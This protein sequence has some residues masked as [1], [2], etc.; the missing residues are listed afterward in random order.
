MNIGKSMRIALAMRDM[1]RQELAQLM[2]V[3]P[4]TVSRLIGQ[5]T[6]SGSVLKNIARAL[7]MKVSEF[8]ALG[9][10]LT[11]EGGMCT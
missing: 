5:Q 11:N 3:T 7:E 9:E 8:V 4:V 6:C 10:Q 1:E 2:G